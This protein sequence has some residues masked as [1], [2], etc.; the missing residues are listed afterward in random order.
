MKCVRRTSIMG[1]AVALLVG[2][3]LLSGCTSTMKLAAYPGSEPGTPAASAEPSTPPPGVPHPA[4]VAPGTGAPTVHRAGELPEAKRATSAPAQFTSKASY[5]DGISLAVSGFTRG[6]I[7]S[8]GSGIITGA[9]YIVF[10]V[11]LTNGSAKSL[12]L[13]SVVATL[14]Y[15]RADTMAAPVYD[16]VKAND[17]WGTL[18]PGATTRAEYAF[19]FPTAETDA[20]L[21]IDLDGAHKAAAFTGSIPK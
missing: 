2:A 16:E 10:N 6:V 4:A 19:Q 1:G 17:F 21:F 3:T 7:K 13:S 9:P 8:H 14:R 5:P 18:K 15:G 12:D 11:T 20:S